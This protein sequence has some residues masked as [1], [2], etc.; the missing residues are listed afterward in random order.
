VAAAAAGRTELAVGKRLLHPL[1]YR[2]RMAPDGRVICRF[3]NYGFKPCR[4]GEACPYDHGHCNRC[5]GAGH[6]ARDCT[7]AEFADAE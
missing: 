2:A 3:H 4:E 6:V 5:G 7:A 1:D